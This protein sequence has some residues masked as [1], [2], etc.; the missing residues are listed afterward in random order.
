M[1]QKAGEGSLRLLCPNREISRIRRPFLSLSKNFFDKLLQ[2]F[3]NFPSSEKLMIENEWPRPPSLAAARQFTLRH[4]SWV[5]FVTIFLPVAQDSLV[6]RQT[7]SPWF[8]A[9]KPRRFPCFHRFHLSAAKRSTCQK[10]PVRRA[11]VLIFCKH[12][13]LFVQ[14]DKIPPGFLEISGLIFY[15]NAKIQLNF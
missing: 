5:S 4:P 10:C 15:E 11:F 8:A 7:I 6:Y 1:L 12:F 13:Y 3:L 14:L 2:V 9:G